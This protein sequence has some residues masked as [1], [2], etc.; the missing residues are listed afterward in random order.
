MNMP[1]Q[2]PVDWFQR[3]DQEVQGW[4]S[5]DSAAALW[6]FAGLNP[7]LGAIVE[8]RSAWGKSTIVLAEASRCACG[9]PVYSVDPHTGGLGCLRQL[10]LEKIDSFP[11]FWTN[12]DKYELTQQVVLL[13]ATS[14]SAAGKWDTHQK[15]RLLYIDGLLTPE[16]VAIDICKWN[17]FVAKGGIVV[18]DDYHQPSIPQYR[19]M[20][21]ELL[22]A[23]PVT[24]PVEPVGG[25]LVYVCKK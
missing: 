6:R 13:V 8:I 2:L 22:P 21:V 12:I 4:C 7:H 24:F 19:A 20:I 16:A 14:E 23:Q 5:L 9:G 17:P 10:G 3:L 25:G 15:I 11:A 1:E 18:F